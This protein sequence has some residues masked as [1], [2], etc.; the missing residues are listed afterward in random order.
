MIVLFYVFSYLV[1]VS[2]IV[3][4]QKSIVHIAA[5]NLKKKLHSRINFYIHKE[6]KE[7]NCSLR[8]DNL[9]P[10]RKHT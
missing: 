2:S 9:R 4:K 5:F 1:G 3:Y 8:Q 6:N 7:K 10:N